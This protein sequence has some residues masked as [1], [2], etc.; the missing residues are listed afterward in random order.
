[1]PSMPDPAPLPEPLASRVGE[2]ERRFSGTLALWVHDLRR[3]Q[4]YGLRD[5]E[6]FDPASTIKLFVLLELY[7]QA[8][9]GR[10]ELDE[11]VTVERRDAVGGSGVLKYLTPGRVRLT[12]RDAAALMITVSDNTATNLLIDRLGP[13]AINRTSWNAGFQGTWLQ[14]KLMRSR[15]RRSRTTP[16]DLGTLLTRLAR[17]QLVSRPASTAMLD[18][19]RREQ[20]DVVVGRLLPDDTF[21]RTARRTTWKVASKSGSIH[22]HRHDAALVE[23]QGLR[24]VVVLMSRDC[25]DARFNVD[26]EASVCLAQVARAVHDH[27]AGGR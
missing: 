15:T 20:S 14:G 7:R 21:D 13:G 19:L 9:A 10:V 6:P 11:E 23:G 8:E 12:L 3:R 27:I 25:Q 24:Y 4:L 26:N 16:R 22:G 5:G 18:I 17:R 2:L 1:M